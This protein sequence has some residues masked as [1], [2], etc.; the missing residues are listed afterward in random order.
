MDVPGAVPL[1]AHGSITSKSHVEAPWLSEINTTST[2][3]KT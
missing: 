2:P 1:L 3:G